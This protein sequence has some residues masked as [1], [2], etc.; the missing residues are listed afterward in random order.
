MRKTYSAVLLFLIGLASGFAA[1]AQNF[2][3]RGR[4][5]WVGY[6]HHQYMEGN[7]TQNMVLYL[8]AEQAAT[9]VVTI[10][11]TAKLGFPLGWRRVYNVPANSVVQTENL[12]KGSTDAGPPSNT[13][14]N[15][16]ARLFDFPLPI[17]SNG[18]GLWRKKG[19]HIES[20]VPIVAYAHIYGGVAS[21]A[22]ML[23]PVET[24]GYSYTSINS[25]QADAGGPGAS[26][27]YIIA[28]DDF[29][30]IRVTPST[31]TVLGK[32]A[33]VPFT[34]DLMKGQ[35]YQI[36]A[37]S[38]AG[39]NGTNF[40]GSTVKS[41]VGADG[42][43]HPI[44]AFSGSGRTVGEDC[45]TGSGRDNDI[46]QCFPEHAWGRR[47]L[48]TPF[49]KASGGI[50]A[51]QF[52][53][54][55][56]KIVVKDAATVVKRNG[57]LLTGLIAGKYYQYSSNT[58]DYIESDKP[59]T[60]AQYMSGGSTCAGGSLGD[61]EMIFLSPIEQAIKSVGFFRNNRQA[62]QYNYLTLVVPTAGLPSLRID[63]SALFDYTYPH[64]QNALLGTNYTV[65]V[66]GWTAAQAQCLVR[67]DSAF[68]AI[69]YGLGGAESYGYNAG[70]FLKNLNAEG[71]LYNKPDTSNTA[72]SFTCTGTPMEISALLPY[73][74]TSMNWRLSTLGAVVSPNADVFV[75]NPTASGT[76]LIG[77]T[78]YY[79]YRLPGTYVFNT[80]GTYD[81]PIVNTS[82]D[83]DN[84]SLQETVQIKI[85][86]KQKPSSDFTF[87][88]SGCRT[89]SVAF[90]GPA[91][92]GTYTIAAWKWQFGDGDS[93]AIKNPKHLYPATGTY[94]VKMV[95]T[96]TEGCLADTTK[97]V[98]IS[99]GA[100]ASITASRDSAC[101]G[102]AINF[103]SGY[104]AAA[105]A[106]YWDFGFGT[107]VTLAANT[108]QTITFPGPGVY[109]VKHVVTPAGNCA[110]DTVRKT[111]S[112]Y[113]LPSPTFTFPNGCLPVNG[114]VQFNSTASAS[115]GQAIST[116]LWNFGDPNATGANPNTAAVPNPSHTYTY[117]TYTINYQVMTVNGCVKDTS[118]TTT[119]NVKPQLYFNPLTAVCENS[120]AFTIANAGVTNAVPGTGVYAGPG[121]A[122]NGA[123]NPAAAGPGLHTIKYLYTS[124]GNCTDSITQTIQ[125]WAAP[126][127]SFTF[128]G[129][130]LPTNGLVQF[131]NTSTISDGQTLSY[132]WDFG[133]PNAT[134]AN[135][136]TSTLQNPSH[137]YTTGTYNIKLTVA[138]AN[139]CSRDTTIITTFTLKPALAYP[140]LAAVCES[141]APYSVATATVTNGVP[142][143]GVYSGPGTNAAGSFNPASAGPG[144]H[145]IKYVFTATGGCQ[146]SVSRTITVYAAPRP[147]FTFPTGCLPVGGV[148]A[149][150]NTTTIADAQT[151][152]Y[153]WNFADPNANGANPNTS[154]TQNPTHAYSYGTYPVKLTVTSANGCVKDTTI[155]VAVNVR[156][157]L[158]YPVLNAVCENVAPLSVAT[159]T[160]GNGVPGAGV[161]SGVGVNAAGQ[162]N[163]AAAGP[164]T[165][166]IKYVFTSTGGCVDSV[167]R[168]ITVYAA[169]K[170]SFTFP[171]GCLP[172]NGLVQF[173]NTSTIADAQTLSYAWNF[174]DPNANGANPNTSTA[175]NPTHLYQYGNYNIQLI[176]NS[177][178]GCSKDTTISA[179]FNVKP[180]LAYSV[181]AAVC[182]NNATSSV[183]NGSVTNNVP[184]TGIYRGPGTTATGSFNP[185]VAG[186]G[187]HTIWYVFTSDGGCTDSVSQT[188][189]VYAAPRAAFTFSTGCLPAN[190]LVQF[191]NG[192]TIADAQTLTYQWNFGDPNANGA[193]PN[194]STLQNPTHLYLDG[195]YPVKLTA[196]S[197]N[198][199]SRDTTINARFTV[200][201]QLSYPALTATCE[202]IISLSVASATVQNAVPG[203]GVY[204][205][206]GVDAAGNFRPGVAGAGV[207]T[208]KYVF[209]STGGCKDSVSQTIRVHAKPVPF[210]T[211]PA[212]CLPV[213]GLAQ[214][215]NATTISDGQSMT[216]TWNFN[217][218]NAN[219]GNPNTSTLQNPTHIFV[220]TGTYNIRLTAVSANGCIGDTTRTVTLS[221]VPQLTFTA[222]PP[223]CESASS[224]TLNAGSV[225][226][227]VTGT[228]VYSGPGVSG[229]GTFNPAAA[230]PGTQTI[231]FTFTSAGGCTDSVSGTITVW[232][233][234]TAT[235]TANSNIC[236]DQQASFTT[237]SSIVSGTIQRYDWDFGDGNTAAYLS[238]APFSRPY[239][240]ANAYLVRLV[241]ISDN[242]C[243]SDADTQTVNVRPLPVANFTPPSFVCFP[244]AA[245][246]TSTATVP[247]NGAL[248][249][250]WDFGDGSGAAST[251]NP[252]YTYA[253][254]NSY[255]VKL[256]VTTPY[257]CSHDT[258]KVFNAFYE[259]PVATFAVTPDTLCQ[260]TDN[261]FTDASFAP[262]STINSW[263][264]N[265]GDNS[266]P[267]TS[268]NPVKRYANPGD[269]TISLTVK[270][271]FGCTSDPF[272]KT[273]TVYL[274]PK[275]DAGPSFIVP[276]GTSVTFRPQVNGTNGIRFTWSPTGN[277]TNPN[278]LTQTIV[279]QRNQV[280]TL[281]AVGLGN[282]T[283]SDTMSVKILMPVV[284]PNSFSP[285]GDGIND[286]WVIPNLAEYPGMTVEV[287]NRYG[288]MVYQ[289]VGYGRPWDGT[290]KGQPLPFATYYYIITLKNGFAPMTGT[291]TIVK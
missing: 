223:L 222:P 85:E 134:G 191:T 227:G 208:I 181:L 15:F 265:F 235:F 218:P 5:F 45:G 40:T 170:P 237:T 166:S 1:E 266:A 9:V 160:V 270:N 130:C 183:A 162:F 89:D 248:T 182:E 247:G 158:S 203:S 289:S 120:P 275:I 254:I 97:P 139:G 8:S 48:T 155:N 146:D 58:A 273:V 180:L 246:F 39:G 88:H 188:I 159:A 42:I 133:D 69:T 136:N 64:P 59:I 90:T 262:N 219:A 196:N 129:G 210:F 241:A 167:S 221:V 268:R 259:K 236:L 152:T 154:T 151:L 84:C 192:S 204:S 2:T 53:N 194:T 25:R 215:T 200:R 287:Y 87:T 21:G 67:C 250:N 271:A 242:G 285:N 187:L 178:N 126:R 291:V 173:T 65:V 238:A 239:A 123:F 202:N 111:I 23:L 106:Y 165:H 12:P 78:T 3:N 179:T 71:E 22:T 91:S 121:T 147:A 61:P 161:Y 46:Q 35:I 224:I 105:T 213:S 62:I 251:T 30:R 263:S 149:F 276:Q 95:V 82:T 290:A 255:P 144:T 56:Y 245:A 267:S 174:G 98:T 190:G 229:N 177:S 74:P 278:A 101:S 141:V 253:A 118:V 234:P 137:T 34:V 52:Q 113:A 73:Q 41:I 128:P 28:K 26:W 283:A 127:P 176:V 115:D 57:T 19:I 131:S 72:R 81:L 83:I 124:T 217:D 156:A 7:N 212:G 50:Q 140:A 172:V 36:V 109:T 148:V 92:T 44:A 38:D 150:N 157:Q 233:K 189:R 43:C 244:G 75:S 201:P 184:G 230:G 77:N 103:S 143:T 132:N 228:G 260:G 29:T 138:T 272:T 94:Q 225:M 232:P 107:P 142:G 164:G 70:T 153:L 206:P 100:Q 281:T 54:S 122:S 108:P 13:D 99:P 279:A 171:N 6:G 24:W 116:H 257:G 76:V 169:P 10:D 193:N 231:R 269:Y 145:T 240:A 168:T 55:I 199:C 33:G 256:T 258:T 264:W 226:N 14:I 51:N 211:Y 284:V 186:P 16:D 220:N 49:S 110:T 66:K 31:S 185:A 195:T 104:A 60:V 86:V 135:P 102:T 216:Y 261:V 163:P 63:N 209:T 286:L 80:A 27:F 280:Y 79:R 277:F 197:S 4:E 274:Q 207:H 125:V 114:V 96:T 32:P 47:Y 198:G 288:Q 249:Y 20:N 18:E 214:F 119:F 175:Q 243:I 68:T 93:A 37:P 17:G 252:S 117:G 205:G 112:I 11:S 282:C